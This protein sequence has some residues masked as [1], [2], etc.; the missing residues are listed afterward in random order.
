MTRKLERSLSILALL[1]MLENQAQAVQLEPAGKALIAVLGTPKAKP[2][3]E[4]KKDPREAEQKELKAFYTTGS[5]AKA[6]KFAFL[7][8]WIWEKQCSHGWVIGVDAKTSKVTEV[9]FIEMQCPHAEPVK[10]A[11][12]NEQFKGKGPAD[13]AKLKDKV[14]TIAKATGSCMIAAKAV[15]QSIRLAAAWKGKY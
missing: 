11:S 9:R 12:F 2:V 5:G 6:T 13:V 8:T 3:K 4:A 7:H 1:V 14:D 10:K 15:A